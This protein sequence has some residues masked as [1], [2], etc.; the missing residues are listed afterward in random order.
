MNTQLG[1]ITISLA[2]FC[3]SCNSGSPGPSHT[4]SAPV[5]SYHLPD[6]ITLTASAVRD[7]SDG[8]VIEGTTN[9][10]PDTKLGI[11]LMTGNRVTAQDYKVLVAV[12]KFRSAGFRKG[13]SPLPP[14]RQKVHILTYFNAIWQPES[15][16][17][18][19]GQGGSNLKPS[20]VVHSEDAQL[21]DGDKVLDYTVDLIVPPLAIASS[22]S[23][24]A[25]QAQSAP[26]DK[27][28]M[29]VKNAVLVVDGSRSSETIENGVRFYFKLPGLRMG[30]G[31]GAT[32]AGKDRF[33]VA[34][35]FINTVGA[36]EQHDSALWEVNVVTK[37]VLY[38]NKY[39][40][41]FSW[42]PKD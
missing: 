35:D 17:T 14:G 31:W 32:S 9:L 40:K 42:I 10:P 33:N 3:V 1:T 5:S 8:T 19:V 39:A 27:A 24:A 29:L 30:N 12:G 34:L 22:K 23:T 15:V 21:I 38:R 11:E 25:A 41:G 26:G 7:A 16:L 18:L 37:K 28:I 20:E 4:A 6:Q 2:L 13:A 36:K